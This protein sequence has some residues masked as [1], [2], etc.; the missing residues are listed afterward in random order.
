MK[1]IFESHKSS[2]FVEKSQTFH[3]K[4]NFYEI[5]KKNLYNAIINA[6]KLDEENKKSGKPKGTSTEVY[7]II[8]E[9][10]QE[11]SKEQKNNFP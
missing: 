1:F 6:K 8:E 5:L 3:S 10:L 2:I 11:H 9:I 4:K 7:K